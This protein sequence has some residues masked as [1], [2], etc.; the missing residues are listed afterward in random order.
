MMAARET[1]RPW[2]R[3]A[4]ATCYVNL[5]FPAL[6]RRVRE[7]YSFAVAPHGNWP[8]LSWK[9]RTE[10]SA[11]ILYYH[12][13][14]DDRDPFFPAISTGVFEEQM[15]FIARHYRVVSLSEMMDHLE[16]GA[17]GTVVAVTFD[18][19]YADNYYNAFPILQRYNL[20]A[21]IFLAT[22]SIDT[23]EPLWFEQLAHALKETKRESVEL[24]GAGALPLGTTAA[25]LDANGRITHI[26]RKAP[27][28]ER[29]ENLADILRRLAVR[30]PEARMLNWDQVR[31]LTAHKIDFGG[32]TV[33][34]PF[35]SKATAETVSWEV[36]A[37]KQ[38]IEQ[39]TGMAAPFFAYP[40]GRSEDFSA[41]A[42]AALRAAGYRAGVTTT[43]GMNYRSTDPMELR[44][45]QPWEEDPAVFAWKLDWYQM[46]ND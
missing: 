2:I 40:N 15:R 45:G 34:H 31:R 24:D 11:R 4:A 35:L 22:G 1:N 10:S 8:P 33:T 5:G 17:P 14:N 39:E 23:G 3:H 30:A 41:T 43:W 37:C 19:G 21:T 7:R 46:V 12:R 26:L 13:V 42:K 27:D 38:R 9:R 29:R 28:A 18:D 6:T 44:R 25:R 36:S 16:T 32:H 20:P